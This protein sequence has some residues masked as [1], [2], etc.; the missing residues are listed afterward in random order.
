MA[1]D[2]LSLDACLIMMEWKLPRE[3]MLCCVLYIK[4]IC[5][6]IT[7]KCTHKRR[8]NSFFSILGIYGEKPHE[9]IPEIAL[10]PL[11]Y[12]YFEEK[13]VQSGIF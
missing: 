1:I 4:Y 6:K 13:T 2:T 9:N 11:K 12:T 7:W 8:K 5:A 3:E 10:N